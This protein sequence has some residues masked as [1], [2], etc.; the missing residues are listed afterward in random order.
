MKKIV[1][2]GAGRSSTSLIDYLLSIANDQ[3]LIIVVLDFDEELFLRNKLKASIVKEE[4][5]LITCTG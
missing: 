4:H 3:D 5:Y 1:I 2:F